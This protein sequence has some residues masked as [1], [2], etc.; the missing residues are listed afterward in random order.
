MSYLW[1]G[2]VLSL[3]QM[4]IEEKRKEGR[5]EKGSEGKGREGKGKFLSFKNK[6][7]MSQ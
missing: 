4:Y 3:L 5:E 7:W 6:I 2:I 1:L